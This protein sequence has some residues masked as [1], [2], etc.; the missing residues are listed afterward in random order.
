MNTISNV[1]SGIPFSFVVKMPP[2][3]YARRILERDEAGKIL[4]SMV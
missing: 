4:R 1:L 3:L 2:P